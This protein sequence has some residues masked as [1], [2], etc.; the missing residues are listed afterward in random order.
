MGKVV[1]RATIVGAILVLLVPAAAIAQSARDLFDRIEPS[2]EL[3][4]LVENPDLF[5]RT[6]L[7]KFRRL[8]RSSN[9]WTREMAAQKRAQRIDWRIADRLRLVGIFDL[10][11]DGDVE[12][13]EGENFIERDPRRKGLLRVL[14]RDVDTDGD[15]RMTKTEIDAYARQYANNYRE[16]WRESGLDLLRYDLNGDNS[17]TPE[18]IASFVHKIRSLLLNQPGEDPVCTLPQIPA[19]VEFQLLMVETGATAA[20]GLPPQVVL[21]ADFGSVGNVVVAVSRD[22]VV[23]R[24]E[25]NPALIERL[26]VTED[27]LA[28]HGLPEEKITRVP[29]TPCTSYDGGGRLSPDAYLN[30]GRIFA[31]TGR[32]SRHL[33]YL[34]SPSIVR[35]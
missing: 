32:T 14:L 25:G 9:V 28:V 35:L 17:V 1:G 31:V 24:F 29:V 2:S 21:S 20:D 7:D 34:G 19:E 4:L 26:I 6:A 18:E 5:A 16:L 23:W 13:E 8:A 27:A 10:D 15:R 33:R 3:A 12:P 30:R 22:P 11:G